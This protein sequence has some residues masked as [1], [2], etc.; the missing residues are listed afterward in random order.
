[1]LQA[2]Y[3][4]GYNGTVLLEPCRAMLLG[5]RRTV[6]VVGISLVVDTANERGAG[7]AGVQLKLAPFKINV[8]LSVCW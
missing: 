6:N 5:P 3:F 8:S 2:S 7:G 1:M 4:P